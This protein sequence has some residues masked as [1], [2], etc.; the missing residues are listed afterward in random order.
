MQEKTVA[1]MGALYGEHV[2][3]GASFS[4]AE[5]GQVMAVAS[6]PSET[7]G[8]PDP[9]RAYLCDLSG[10]AYDLVSG[11]A[12]QALVDAT[13]CGPKL[14]VGESRWECALTAD[15]HVAS[16]PLITRTGDAEYVLLDPSGRGE[17][18]SAWLSFI[19]GIEQD[20]YAPYKEAAIEDATDMLVP[21]V[22]CGGAATK[23]LSDYVDKTSDLPAAGC[24]KSIFLD[25][26]G[27]VVASADLGLAG[28]PCYLVL[29]PKARA[30]VL[31]RSFLSFEQVSPVGLD[32]IRAQEASMLPWG[33]LLVEKGQVDAN[34]P[35]LR[36]WGLV[37]SSRDFVGARF[38]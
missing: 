2:L 19:A 25:R 3:L 5:D 7:G 9:D 24:A 16:V 35:E 17:F 23:V 22:L 29:V 1:R 32:T 34:G 27:C 33:A 38:V 13:F 12:A 21:L 18:A 4:P 11:S 31:W 20:G 8:A 14:K 15:G 37:R 30:V 26:I 6:Y 10:S 36:A 28:M